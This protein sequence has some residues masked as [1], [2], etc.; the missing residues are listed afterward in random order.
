VRGIDHEEVRIVS[1][2]CDPSYGFA[3]EHHCAV[4]DL[5]ILRLNV[6]VAVEVID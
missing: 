2:H 6:S 5:D 3:T 4:L 1:L